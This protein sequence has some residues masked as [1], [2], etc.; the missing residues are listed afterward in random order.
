VFGLL[1]P[2]LVMSARYFEPQHGAGIGS[3]ETARGQSSFSA[4]T[5]LPSTTRHK[6]GCAPAPL[7]LFSN[8]DTSFRENLGLFVEEKVCR[9]G[10]KAKI[11]EIGVWRGDFAEILLQRYHQSIG[12]YV[13]IEPAEKLTGSRDPELNRRLKDF[14]NKFPNTNFTL[15]D[16]ISTEAVKRFPDEYFDWVYCDGLHTY[17]GVQDD[18]SSFWSKVKVGGLFSGHD[19]SMSRAKAR[20]DPWNTIAPWSGVRGGTEKAGFPGSYKA[21]VQ[22]A[23]KQGI[24]VFYTL[25]GRYGQGMW[26]LSD[27]GGYFR[28]NPSWFMF[29]HSDNY[30]SPIPKHN[31]IYKWDDSRVFRK[32]VFGTT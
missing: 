6:P 16:E 1:I 20:S 30:T 31:Y 15:I 13:M 4:H 9:T 14:P 19:F 8:P 22:H 2:I 27:T 21:V 5:V 11:V 7:E 12:E 10:I 24:Q 26:Q 25:E 17:K 3:L 18:V 32:F 29:K 23:R 28:N